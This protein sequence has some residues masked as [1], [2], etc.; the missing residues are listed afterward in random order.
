MAGHYSL[1]EEA[2]PEDAVFSKAAKNAHI[3]R[4]A[5]AFPAILLFLAFALSI[6]SSVLVRAGGRLH[7]AVAFLLGLPL[8]LWLS[9]RIQLSWQRRFFKKTALAVSRRLPKECAGDLVTLL[10]GDEPKIFE[11]FFAWDFG[12]LAASGDFMVYTGERTSFSLPRAAIVSIEILRRRHGWGRFYSLLVR[13][14]GGN[15]ILRQAAKPNSRRRI[16]KLQRRWSAWWTAETPAP[17]AD[18]LPP[19]CPP[20]EMPVTNQAAAS[21]KAVTFLLAMSFLLLIAGWAI[22]ALLPSTLPNMLA[23]LAAPVL[24]LSAHLPALIGLRRLRRAARASA[25]Q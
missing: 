1:P 3:A 10:P 17:V 7:P 20:A 5:F 25:G 21:G 15:F 4:M 14:Q 24:Y 6:L 2:A 23:V 11:G 13:W 18:P 22:A 19:G 16:V 9:L 8:A 12:K